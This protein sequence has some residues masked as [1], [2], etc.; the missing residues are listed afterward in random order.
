MVKCVT[1]GGVYTAILSDGTRYFHACPPLS[2]LEVSTA[3]SLDPDSTK[4][5]P[6]Q[7][8]TVAATARA[9][10]NGR[11]ENVPSTKSDDVGKL[12]AI[13]GGTLVV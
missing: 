7:R 5:T 12:K 1:C 4:Q 6:A 8:A 11:D 13:G 2:D 9:R 3:L 10:P